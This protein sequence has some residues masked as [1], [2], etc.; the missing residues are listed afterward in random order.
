MISRSDHFPHGA[1][2]RV[3]EKTIFFVSFSLSD[4]FKALLPAGFNNIFFIGGEQ[5]AKQQL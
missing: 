1:F 2:E 5:A 4:H 3:L